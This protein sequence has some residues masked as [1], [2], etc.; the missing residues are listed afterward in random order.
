MIGKLTPYVAVGV[1]QTV[2]ILVLAT[3]V[4]LYGPKLMAVFAVLE[5][6]EATRAH[7]GIGA[8]LASAFWESVFATL[9]API[10]MLQR[11]LWIDIHQKPEGMVLF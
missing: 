11:G 4:L 2:V 10:V 3:L 7:G 1:I 9:I 6:P 8:V 5:S